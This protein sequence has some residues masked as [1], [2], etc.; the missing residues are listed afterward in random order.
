MQGWY[1][2]KG[3]IY[4]MANTLANKISVPRGQGY[5]YLYVS[6]T[7]IVSTILDRF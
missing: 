4:L 2:G 6:R 3:L 7:F 5:L 1:Y